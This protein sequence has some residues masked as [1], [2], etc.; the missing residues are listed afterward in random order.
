MLSQVKKPSDEKLEE[1]W[2]D[3]NTG[4]QS[5]TFYIDGTEVIVKPRWPWASLMYKVDAPSA[6]LMWWLWFQRVLSGTP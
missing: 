3:F 5:V 4:S 6:L 1:F 2:I